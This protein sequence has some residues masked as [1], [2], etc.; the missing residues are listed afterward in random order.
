MRAG[1]ISEG[2]P[3]R[4]GLSKNKEL[5]TCTHKTAEIGVLRCINACRSQLNG[6]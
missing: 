2:Q 6:K 4:I 3:D 1:K 5:A